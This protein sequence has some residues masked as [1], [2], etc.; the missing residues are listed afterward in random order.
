MAMKY[1][2]RS[3]AEDLERAVLWSR[4]LALTCLP[5]RDLPRLEFLFLINLSSPRPHA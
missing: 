3:R 2:F 5:K 4:C 1:S